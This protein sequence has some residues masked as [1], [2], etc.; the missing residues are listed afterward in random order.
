MAAGARDAGHAPRGIAPTVGGVDAGEG[1]TANG[2]W[3]NGWYVARNGRTAV[4]VA[5]GGTILLVEIDGRLP[6][7]SV[8]TSIPETAAVMAWLG[9]M[10]AVNLDGG[11]SSNMVIGGK[12]VGHPSDATGERGA[13]DTLMLLPG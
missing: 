3:Y 13:G 8:G 4:G 10:S 1:G 2:N 7:L 5:A 11:G 12:A 6:A 9:A